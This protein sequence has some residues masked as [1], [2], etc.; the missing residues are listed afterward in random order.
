MDPTYDFSEPLKLVVIFRDI[1]FK[2]GDDTS[3]TEEMLHDL[4]IKV[5]TKEREF[6][7]NSGEVHV[8][9]ENIG[10]IK[11]YPY[12]DEW[13][14]FKGE[15]FYIDVEGQEQEHLVYGSREQMLSYWRMFRK[16]YSKYN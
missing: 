15:K 4:G 6:E 11:S 14:K 10:A 2:P 13:K 5:G 3:L 16:K 8:L 12:K 9:W 7:E 1:V